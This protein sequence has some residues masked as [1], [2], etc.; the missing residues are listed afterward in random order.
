MT[1]NPEGPP[2]RIDA[3]A[4]SPFG[5]ARLVVELA[6]RWLEPPLPLDS[7]EPAQFL[8]ERDGQTHSF[9]EIEASPDSELP[10]EDAYSASFVVPAEFE[11][12]LGRSLLLLASGRTVSVPPAMWTMV[13]AQSET[14]HAPPGPVSSATPVMPVPDALRNAVRGPG[15][16]TSFG[17]A[18]AAEPPPPV[19]PAP[20][21]PPLTQIIPPPLAPRPAPLTPPLVPEPFAETPSAAV[22]P[23]PL[24]EP[25]A[26]AE[27][28]L[29][30]SLSA[31]PGDASVSA[32]R[33]ELRE[34]VA[35]ETRLRR[36]V[37]ELRAQLEQRIQNQ[38]RL[39]ATQVQLR[40][41]FV[42]LRDR[43]EAELLRGSELQAA[44]ESLEAAHDAHDATQ[45]GLRQEL[46][47]V[48]QELT[49]A[50]AARDHLAEELD[51]ALGRLATLEAE[52]AS[53]VVAR[54]SAAGEVIELRSEL[55]H[56]G[57]EFAISRD[58]VAADE[59]DDAE[60]L[61]AEARA[62]TARL[63]NPAPTQIDPH[64]Q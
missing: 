26:V 23:P 16:P 4:Y 38:E 28:G 17:A 50:E 64:G 39:E 47:A 62:L 32:L 22:L 15:T 59:I 13:T 18:R 56:I 42:E 33:T 21:T 36:N 14:E 58:P 45:A 19:P 6:G 12:R 3:A 61:L 1:T 31:G 10:G 44:N 55:D 41:A 24:P 48:R 29:P 54:D 40:D 35:A 2:L 34:R 30:S 11:G 37:S 25:A 57:A 52:L 49:N 5:E 53:V 20:V 51:G 8:L 9:P 46:A 43:L 60:A 7:S 63:Q 27:P